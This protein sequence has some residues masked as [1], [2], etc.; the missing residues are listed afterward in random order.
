MGSE[1]SPKIED[2]NKKKFCFPPLTPSAA[3]GPSVVC[4]TNFR[5]LQQKPHLA[6]SPRTPNTHSKERQ[7]CEGSG[8]T[9]SPTLA[10]SSPLHHRSEAEPGPPRDPP[11]P[12]RVS[13][14]AV[15]AGAAAEGAGTW[16]GPRLTAVLEMHRVGQGGGA[17]RQ[18][19]ER[20]GQGT[21]RS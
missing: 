8:F 13:Q 20:G 1:K 18:E 15:P 21:H 2:R 3:Q 9:E 7:S 14:R 6:D 4:L 5:K 16:T 11:D 10:H 19:Q 12:A 17:Q